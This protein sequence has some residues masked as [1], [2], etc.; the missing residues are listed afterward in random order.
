MITVVVLAMRQ[1]RIPLTLHPRPHIS[2]ENFSSM[3]MPFWVYMTRSLYAE[4][5]KV[6]PFFAISLVC[7]G[8]LLY[9]YLC[10]FIGEKISNFGKESIRMFIQNLSPSET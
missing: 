7:S 4:S 8:D 5:S 3:V 10:F 9:R 6:S 2:P 1:T